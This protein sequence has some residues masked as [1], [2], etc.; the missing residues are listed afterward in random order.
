MLAAFKA[1][2]LPLIGGGDT[3]NA[4]FTEAGGLKPNDEVR[5]AGVRVGKVKGVDLEG[6]HV[7]VDVQGRRRHRVRHRDRRRDQGQDPA[8]ARCTSRSSPTGSGQLD[9]G[10]DDPAVA[11]HVAVRRRRGVL[12]PGRRAPSGSTPTSCAKSLNT[13][14]D[15]DQGHARRSSRARSRA[16]RLSRQRGHPRRA[17]QHAAAATRTRSPASSPT[18]TSD[19]VTLMND[20]DV[21]LR[22][23]GRAPRGRAPAAGLDQP[24]LAAA[25]RAGPADPRATSSPR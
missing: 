23:A 15:R 13:L 5:I 22:G 6:D 16:L 14:A 21:L 3:Y 2:D 10:L 17:D 1:D 25:D 18:A 4:T 9:G 24:A 20:S 12:R 19:I 7:E 8:R 11:H